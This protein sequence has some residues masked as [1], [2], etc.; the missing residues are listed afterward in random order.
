VK[1]FLNLLCKKLS[2][3]WTNLSGFEWDFGTTNSFSPFILFFSLHCDSHC[4][5]SSRGKKLLPLI[6]LFNFSKDISAHLR[7]IS[8]SG[9][10]KCLF[11]ERTNSCTWGVVWWRRPWQIQ[12]VDKIYQSVPVIFCFAEASRCL[13]MWR[14]TL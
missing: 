14:S 1:L 4:D 6:E 12:C 13:L 2:E 11:W 9:L 8:V 7:Q 5:I 3:T 10:N